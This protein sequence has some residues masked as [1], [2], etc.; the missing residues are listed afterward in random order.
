MPRQPVDPAIASTSQLPENRRGNP[1][2]GAKSD[3]LHPLKL[4]ILSS[5]LLAAMLVKS[6][7]SIS[8]LSLAL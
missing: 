3:A 7:F 2:H 5:T 8:A 1:R 4:V 6:G